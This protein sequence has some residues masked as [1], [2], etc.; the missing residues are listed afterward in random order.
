METM[1][2]SLCRELQKHKAPRHVDMNPETLL[3]H[4][5]SLALPDL[6]V[7]QHFYISRDSTQSNLIFCKDKIFTE[8]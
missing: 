8:F 6:T 3:L 1:G 4:A 2:L 5:V 7:S